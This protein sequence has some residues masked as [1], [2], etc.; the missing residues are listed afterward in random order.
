MTLPIAD[1]NRAAWEANSVLDSKLALSHARAWQT[2]YGE[3]LASGANV[4]GEPV[5][6]P[7]GL[8]EFRAV[9]PEGNQLTLGQPFE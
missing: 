8:R 4:Q 6:H 5:S 2:L 3:L 1:L 7:W 9:D